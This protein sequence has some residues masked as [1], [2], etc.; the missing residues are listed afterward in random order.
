MKL[1]NKPGG[2]AVA[3]NVISDSEFDKQKIGL[4]VRTVK[5]VSEGFVL[6]PAWCLEGS[7]ISGR[8]GADWLV[9]HE[10]TGNQ[11]IHGDARLL[12]INPDELEDEEQTEKELENQ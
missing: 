6:I 9:I 3:T 11:W 8:H 5:T 7:M 4:V 1:R 12:P 2:L 10:P